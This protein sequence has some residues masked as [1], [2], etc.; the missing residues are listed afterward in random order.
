MARSV[1]DQKV[2]DRASVSPWHGGDA[3]SRTGPSGPLDQCAH[4]GQAQAGGWIGACFLRQANAIVGNLQHH[5]IAFVGQGATAPFP[6]HGRSKACSTA[7]SRSSLATNAQAVA[8][9]LGK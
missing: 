6:C 4:D 8:C 9:W 1:L 7:L 2:S 3:P 5:L